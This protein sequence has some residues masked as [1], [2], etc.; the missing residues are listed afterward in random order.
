MR[1]LDRWEKP[2]KVA[3]PEMEVEVNGRVVWRGAMFAEDVYKPVE[4]EIPVDA[5]QRSNTFKIRNA[6]PFV[7]DQGRPVIHYVVLRK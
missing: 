5:I 3:P 7:K 4:I 6:G 1:Y 2:P